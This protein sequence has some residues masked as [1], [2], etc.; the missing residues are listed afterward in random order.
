MNIQLRMGRLA[1]NSD[2]MEQERDNETMLT[3]Y[4]GYREGNKCRTEA[5]AYLWLT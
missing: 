2:Q 1:T 5:P 3:S 4:K